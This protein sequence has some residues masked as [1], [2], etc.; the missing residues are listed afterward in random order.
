MAR[1]FFVCI[2]VE[3][4][5]NNKGQRNFKSVNFPASLR[6]DN[7]R[8]LLEIVLCLRSPLYISPCVEELP[9]KRRAAPYATQ[10][11]HSDFVN[12]FPLAVT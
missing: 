12:F 2:S 4:K 1:F 8:L 6:K 9:T 7:I 5:K 3:R 10:L 11:L